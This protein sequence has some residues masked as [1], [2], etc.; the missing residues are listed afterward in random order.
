MVTSPSQN[1]EFCLYYRSFDNLLGSGFLVIFSIVTG[2]LMFTEQSEMM[3]R[4][5]LLCSILTGALAILSF[6]LGMRLKRQSAWYVCFRPDL[7]RI[8][9]LDYSSPDKNQNP[10]DG[11]LEIPIDQLIWIRKAV[12]IGGGDDSDLCFLD[13][14]VMPSTRATARSLRTTYWPHSESLAGREHVG[15]VAF[16]ND[17]ILRIRLEKTWP[18]DLNQY[19]HR[20]KFPV[21]ADYEIKQVKT[22]Q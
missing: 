3:M 14:C 18:K 15:R 7:L 12:E 13:I 20:W 6:R 21:A 22:L 16:F 17:D 2:S 1:T 9:F 11:I 4:I 10:M 5:F 19:L 8:N